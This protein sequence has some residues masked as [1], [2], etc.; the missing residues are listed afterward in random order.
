MHNSI[1]DE[2]SPLKDLW[3]QVAGGVYFFVFLSNVTPDRHSFEN[4]FA[5][6]NVGKH[7]LQTHE[8]E[9]YD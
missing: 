1:A 7:L 2:H 9:P 5:N 8:H 3:N 4:E 6:E